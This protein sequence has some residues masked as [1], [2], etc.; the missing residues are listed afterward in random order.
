MVSFTLPEEA[1]RIRDM[2]RDFARNE[3][4]PAG[5]EIDRISDPEAA[6][7]S[8]RMRKVLAGA[9]E[10][11]FH[12]LGLPKEVGGVGAPEMTSIIVQE[13]LAVGDAGL[14]SH[15]L[16]APM[17]AG[18]SAG[19]KDRHP[20]Y[21]E[22]LEAF[23]EDTKGAHSGAW[24]IT[25]P[26][27]GSDLFQF[28]QP[29]IH[30]EATATKDGDEYVVNGQKSAFVSNGW[31]ADALLLMVNLDPAQ[32]MEGTVTFAIPGNLPGITRGKPLNKL[33][34]RGLN[35]AEIYFDNVRIPPEFLM[36]PPGAA[37]RMMLE[38]IVTGGNTA[39]GTL[40]VGV[41]RAAY[42]EALAYAKDRVQGGRRICEHDTVKLKLFDAYR[43]I[44]AARAL[45]WKS[46]W[47]ISTG[48]PHLPTAMAA[49][50]MASDMA[51][52]VTADMVQVFGGYGISKEHPVEKFYRD[53][54][55]L[56]IMDGTNEMVSLK[57][58]DQL[59]AE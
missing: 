35:Q 2:T 21:K 55:L 38:R 47:L 44:E 26:H 8:D 11:G 19:A 43:Q 39:V 15:L 1:E 13:E 46:S 17:I 51:M 5:A 45:L 25:E 48:R 40:A 33:G 22:Y 37:Y 12:K 50:T 23:V 4:R 41:A 42:E 24:A 54:K 6:Y 29:D 16:V 3:I 10:L 49:R 34:L 9:Y 36:L 56:Q 52:R 59:L 32:G 31:M 7:T 58:A 14:A 28:G 30:M 57:A 27:H 53:A 20:F 18:I